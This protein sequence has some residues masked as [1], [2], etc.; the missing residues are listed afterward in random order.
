M[1]DKCVSSILLVLFSCIFNSY[2]DAVLAT[3]YAESWRSR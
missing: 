1:T 3:Q 2:R